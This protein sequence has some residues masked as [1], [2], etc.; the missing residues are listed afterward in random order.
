MT[1][2]ADIMRSAVQA[3]FIFPTIFLILKGISVC[4]NVEQYKYKSITTIL[5]SNITT[6]S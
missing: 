4:I 5:K 3:L 2:H 6:V 1:T